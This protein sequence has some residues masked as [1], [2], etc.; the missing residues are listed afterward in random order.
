MAII[1]WKDC[2][3][4]DVPEF[5]E[6]HKDLVSMIN[7]L[8]EAI[9]DHNQAEIKEKILTSLME[10]VATHLAHE[11][12]RMEELGYPDLAAHKQAHDSFRNDVAA[13][14]EMANSGE[15][16]LVSDMYHLLRGWLLAH[17]VEVDKK[18]TSF[19]LEKTGS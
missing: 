12:A 6:E 18:Y 11:E 17:I 15:A 13:L 9:R 19:F 7:A 3:A 16:Y 4:T 14:E 8:Y 2:Y 10:Y 5:D 1:Q